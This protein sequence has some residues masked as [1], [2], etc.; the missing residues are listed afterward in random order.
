MKYMNDFRQARIAELTQLLDENLPAGFQRIEVENFIH[1]VVPLTIY[2]K[3]Y[4]CTPGEPLPFISIANQK[5]YVS[6]YHFG[7]Y[8]STDL[9]ESFVNSHDDDKF[10]KLNIGKSCIRFKDQYNLPRTSL[11][12][13]FKK[14]T[15]LKFVEIYESNRI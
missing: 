13:L 1:Y 12:E 2:P 14:I 9:Q 5:N 4:H 11:I 15:P 7:L 6:L 8:A 3:G 10:G